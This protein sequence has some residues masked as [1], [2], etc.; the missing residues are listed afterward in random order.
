MVG[1]A[2]LASDDVSG[3]VLAVEGVARDDGVGQAHVG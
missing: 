2:L 1:F 3:F